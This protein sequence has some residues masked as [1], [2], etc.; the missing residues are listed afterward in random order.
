MWISVPPACKRYFNDIFKEG[1]YKTGHSDLWLLC[2]LKNAYITSVVLKEIFHHMNIYTHRG[3]KKK[4]FEQ[5]LI[6]YC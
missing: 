3:R 5:W 4:N 1:T 6:I 2:Y